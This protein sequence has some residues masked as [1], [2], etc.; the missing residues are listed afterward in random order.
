MTD[1][2]Y[3]I[4]HIQIGAENYYEEIAGFISCDKDTLITSD[5]LGGVMYDNGQ[6]TEFDR[7]EKHP[8]F[9]VANKLGAIIYTKYERYEKD[10]YL[11]IPTA[12]HIYKW[13]RRCFYDEKNT[14][15]YIK[16]G[17]IFFRSTQ[18]WIAVYN[19]EYGIGIIVDDE[20]CYKPRN[21]LHNLT[22]YNGGNLFFGDE[23]RKADEDLKN[24]YNKLFKECLLDSI[25]DNIFEEYAR[26][27][28][29]KSDTYK[30]YFK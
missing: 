21:L 23:L 3:T 5:N 17:D 7:T 11:A 29:I 25:K 24:N 19:I 8:L 6:L 4:A 27:G 28:V 15:Y 10:F 2:T 16:A 1:L 12:Y 22:K 18:K 14:S 9:E 13:E 20:G 30:Q 26:T